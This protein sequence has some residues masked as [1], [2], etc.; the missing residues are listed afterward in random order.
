MPTQQRGLTGN[1]QDVDANNNG[2]V[3][4]PLIDTQAGFAAMMAENDAGSVIGTRQMRAVEVSKD[5]RVRTGQDNMVFNESFPGA[6]INTGLWSNPTTT[7][8]T[9]TVNGFAVINAGLSV[10]IGAVAQLRTYRHFPC[11]KQYTTYAEMEVQLS[12]LPV[13]GNRCEWGLSLV[14]GSSASTDGAFF[15]LE[16]TGVFNGVLNYNGTETLTA[17][18]NVAQLGVNITHSYLIYVGSSFVEFWVDNILVGS[19]AR[20]PGQGATTSSTNLPLSFR[21]YNVTATSTAQVMRIGNVNVTFGDQAM[22][23]PWGHVLSGMGASSIQGQTGSPLGSTA[24]I[25]NAATAAAAALTNTSAAA[26]FVGLGGI[27]NV[28]PTLVVGTDGILC[29]YQVPLGTSIAPGKSL[30]ITDIRISSV[31][32]TALAGGP[33][34][35]AASLAYG[36]NA[37]SLATTESAATKAPRRLGLGVI[38][39]LAAA[40]VG[41]SANSLD[42][43]L[44]AGLPVVQP[45]EFIQV[46]LRNLGVV[47]ATGAITFIISITGYW[48]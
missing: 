42:V 48:E 2:K 17:N 37:V 22:S 33:V 25:N 35:Y 46:A 40:A 23:K 18:I 27:F 21:N 16:S 44:S 45:G 38:P 10:A 20:P 30:Y 11:F 24:Q 6:A 29:S 13:T 47:T 12:S 43:Y 36:H 32:T 26:Q 1:I 5:F 4:L 31:V 7:M 9:T 8:T 41:T 28:L 14:S 34:I 15:R 39:Y 19:I 3:N